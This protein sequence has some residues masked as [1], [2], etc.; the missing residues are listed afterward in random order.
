MLQPRLVVIPIIPGYELWVD[1]KKSEMYVKKA[2]TRPDTKIE[3][4]SIRVE[5]I[6]V[7][8]VNQEELVSK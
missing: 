3:S 6:T 7:I 2:P 1:Q 4:M 8:H 5:P